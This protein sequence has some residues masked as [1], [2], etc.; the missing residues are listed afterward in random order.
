MVSDTR[1]HLQDSVVEVFI[2]L[3]TLPEDDPDV[4]PADRI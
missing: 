4:P 3:D 1:T 2:S